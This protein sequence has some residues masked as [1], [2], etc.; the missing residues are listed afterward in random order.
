M[1]IMASL[2]HRKRI[3][4]QDQNW[5]TV[6]WSRSQ[7]TKTEQS[8]L[9]DILVF[10]PGI[11]EDYASFFDMSRTWHKTSNPDTT[12]RS[13]TLEAFRTAI[14]EEIASKLLAL[15]QWRWAWQRQ[16]GYT[17]RAGTSREKLY[18]SAPDLPSGHLHFDSAVRAADIA[19]YNSL[20]MWFVVILWNI[21]LS[22]EDVLAV[23]LDCGE[24][25][26][27]GL[28][29]PF[30][31][32]EVFKEEF[33]VD[34]WA[35]FQPLL[36]PATTIGLRDL[37]IEICR[38]F[39]WQSLNHHLAT[40]SPQAIYLYM[41]PLG[42]A[43]KVLEAEDPLQDWIT[44]MVKTDPITVAYASGRHT[45]LGFSHFVTPGMIAGIEVVTPSVPIHHPP[46]WPIS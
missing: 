43:M 14:K 1:K 22:G 15:Y 33:Q 46:V 29:T 19:L 8:K 38:V 10:V 27:L 34:E 12:S 6:P 44:E 39:E 45:S 28:L 5:L 3:F 18:K 42:M 21:G 32:S 4:L 9:L 17:V 23:V 16:Y 41:F 7:S 25:A 40:R 35:F 26:R 31:R 20:L 37:A 30:K 13:P 36:R 2:F 11:L 24:K